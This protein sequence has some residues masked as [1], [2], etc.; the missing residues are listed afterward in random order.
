[1]KKTD[2]KILIAALR[3]LVR[4]IQSNDGIANACIAE[5]ANR[6][7]ELVEIN[8]H[9]LNGVTKCLNDNL[10][11]SDGDVC[12]LIDLKNALKKIGINPE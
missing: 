11:L 8:S 7:E 2:D 5:A 10:H 3:I 4:D 9:L 1:M 6:L 12:T